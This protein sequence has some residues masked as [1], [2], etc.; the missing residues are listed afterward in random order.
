MHGFVPLLPHTPH[1]LVHPIH[2]QVYVL[3]GPRVPQN[4]QMSFIE[5]SHTLK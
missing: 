4:P 1:F 3:T 5:E 2:L